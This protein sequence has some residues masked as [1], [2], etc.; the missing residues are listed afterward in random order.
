MGGDC[1]PHEVER[2]SFIAKDLIP[3]IKT[4]WY[5]GFGELPHSV[6]I[7]SFDYLKLGPF[8]ESLGGLKSPETNQRLYK[9]HPDG[10][11]EDITICLRGNN[12]RNI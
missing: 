3:G 8:I 4:A 5:S 6:D 12:S 7:L 9:I 2:L 10:W 1:L 11:R